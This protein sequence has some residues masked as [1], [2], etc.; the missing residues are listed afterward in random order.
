MRTARATAPA[1]HFLGVRLTVEEAAL[2]EK[3]RTEHELSNR[4]DAVRTLVRGASE[5]PATSV[6]LPATLRN[7]L[8]DLVEE[9]YAND[10]D[11]LV[12]LVLTAG[13]RELARTH[14]KDLATLREIARAAKD[15]RAGRRQADREGRGFLRR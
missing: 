13:I 11:S 10:L 14:D 15:R 12:T 4:S 7:E 6:D 9:G 8:E 2:L 5:L 1:T 3:F